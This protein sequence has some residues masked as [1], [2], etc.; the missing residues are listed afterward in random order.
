MKGLYV[1]HF[2]F[3]QK[4]PRQVPD[5]PEEDMPDFEIGPRPLGPP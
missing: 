5:G 2:F 3:S 4:G 1:T